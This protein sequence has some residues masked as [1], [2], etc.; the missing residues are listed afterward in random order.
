V[1]L[2]LDAPELGE[3]RNHWTVVL[4]AIFGIGL[5]TVYH[6]STGVMIGPLEKEFGWSRADISLG[7]TIVA[8]VGCIV[9]PFMGMA[10][11]RFGAR[12]IAIFGVITL[13]GSIAM[14]SQAGPSIWSWWALWC[15]M[16]VTHPFIKPTVWVAAVTS[17]FSTGRGMALAVALTGT[18]VGTGLTPIITHYLIES[19]GWR[20]AYMGLGVIWLTI[21]LPLVLFGFY[22]VADVER[23]KRQRE[24]EKKAVPLNLPGLGKKEA[25][26]SIK[27]FKIATATALVSAVSTAFGV[28]LVPLLAEAEV[29]KA[30]AAM[31][32]GAM[33]IAGIIGKL[34]GGYLIDRYNASR[35][36]AFATACPAVTALLL[37][38]IPGSV[39]VAI[40]AVAINGLALGIEFDGVGYLSSRHFGLKHFG[41]IYGTIVGV[42]ALTSGIAP[43]LANYGYDVSGTYAA[44]LW[45]MIPIA[46]GS[47]LL[48]GTLGSYP[49]FAKTDEANAA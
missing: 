26:L 27:F 18:S 48:F 14:L 33:G 10:I 39:P 11:D 15:L 8:V 24:P 34:T 46:L 4:A 23:Q 38:F 31:V 29:P 7:I 19:Y 13:C 35:V 20:G 9:A 43:W 22:S 16:A 17:L 3:W 25:M 1:S 6:Y 44:L 49:I 12:R 42:L 41:F 2:R 36:V 37:I 32:A 45:S 5:V 47:S 28:N 30:T 21:T 40:V